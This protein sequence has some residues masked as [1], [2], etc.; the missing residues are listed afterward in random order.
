MFFL[1]VYIVIPLILLISLYFATKFPVRMA[2]LLF[3][4]GPLVGTCVLV[5]V[6]ELA[7]PNPV[8]ARIPAAVP[9][10]YLLYGLPIFGMWVAITGVIGWWAIR[11]VQIVRRMSTTG[12]ELAGAMLGSVVGPVLVFAFWTLFSVD[13]AWPNRDRISNVMLDP[14]SLLSLIAQGVLAG[15]VCGPIVA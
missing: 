2:V 6:G 15:I 5:A 12:R 11:R 4:L 13:P 1:G 10:I 3:F 7:K 8:I 9:F 14:I